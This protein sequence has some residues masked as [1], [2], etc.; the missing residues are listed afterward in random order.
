MMTSKKRQGK[1]SSWVVSTFSDFG[2]SSS[3]PADRK[4][5]KR[6]RELDS[7]GEG[8]HK[9]PEAAQHLQGRSALWVDLYAPS[10]RE[11]LAVHKKKVQE[12]ESW[13]VES[14]SGV[15]GRKLLLLT[16]PSGCGKSAT[17]KV[18]AREAG[19]NLVEWTNPTTT[20]YNNTFMEQEGV[21]RPGDTVAPVSQTTQFWDFLMRCSKYSSVCRLEKGGNLVC[22]EDFPNAIFRDPASFHTML[23]KYIQWSNSSSLVFIVTDS[24]QQQG[25]VKQLF[26][27]DL[28]QQLNIVNIAFNPIASG[29]LVKA[30]SRILS[31]ESAGEGG[32]RMPQPPKDVLM[33]LAEA[34][35]GDIRSAINALHF[36]T[37]KDLEYDAQSETEINDAARVY[38]ENEPQIVMG[39]QPYMFE[40]EYGVDEQVLAEPEDQQ[41]DLGTS[42]KHGLVI[43]VLADIGNI[44]CLFAGSSKKDKCGGRRKGTTKTRPAGSE[45]AHVAVG[46]KDASLF[47]FRALGKVL[48][49]KRSS[50]QGVTEPL[51]KHLKKHERLP[52]QE[53]PEG[54]YEKTSMGAS[55]FSL[56]LHQNYL[57]FALDMESVTRAAHYLSDSD[58]ISAEWMERDVLEGY[59]A[60]VTA[61]GLMHPNKDGTSGGGWRP[62]TR[63]QWYA[64]TRKM[65]HHASALK[66][67]HCTSS[68][69]T[70]ELMTVLVPM[71]C[72]ILTGLSHTAQE[73]GW[74][75]NTRRMNYS[76]R[77]GELDVTSAITEP[78]D[79]EGAPLPV[80]PGL[81]SVSSGCQLE[82]DPEEELIIEDP[83]DD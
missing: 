64:V 52:L 67:E 36:A 1:V 79:A 48:Y 29:L 58:V 51:P 35:G 5:G 18:L 49:C 82:E 12:V 6:H 16:G 3:P 31:I 70:E 46:G 25:S 15:K 40:P 21:W 66:A 54:I 2:L 72:K 33:T 10:T 78:E 42:P 61:R 44:E 63:P 81:P 65:Q 24:T 75:S 62:L 34:S 74:L 27:P 76:E 41:E 83:D 47:L 69:T 28:I 73:V 77:L 60:S 57:S 23:R 68:L 43:F 14:S 39:A 37:K 59:S 4:A 17:V 9:R 7:R 19:L 53:V 22:V 30:L 13:L 55:S 45:E 80:F 32:L 71:K 8:R 11:D 50:D 38:E 20:P 26:P 56:F